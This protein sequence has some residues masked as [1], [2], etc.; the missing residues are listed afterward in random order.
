MRNEAILRQE[1]RDTLGFVRGLIHHYSGL[2]SSENLT[3]DV[4]EFCDVMTADGAPC[5]RLEE[6]RR[7]VE[8]RCSRLAQA[9]DRFARRDPA[10]I[11]A[12]RAQAVAAIDL[13]Q[14]A[15]FEWRKARIPSPSSG[16]LLRR[17]SL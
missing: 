1:I 6:A 10:Q 8:E 7:L 4:L 16:H 17:K 12:S 14:D 9:A 5:P 15:V 11:A 13:L 3:R 2:Y